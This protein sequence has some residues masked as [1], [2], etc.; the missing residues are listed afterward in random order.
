M[1]WCPCA[2]RALSRCSPFPFWS[3]W[4]LVDCFSP[5]RQFALSGDLSRDGRNFFS[6]ATIF[7]LNVL[8]DLNVSSP[9]EISHPVRS[10]FRKFSDEAGTFRFPLQLISSRSD[11]SAALKSRFPKITP[12]LTLFSPFSTPPP[13]LESTKIKSDAIFE[14]A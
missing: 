13:A 10:S 7:L 8:R 3:C 9:L 1:E 4:L 14:T 5:L 2:F 11:H 6:P 12:N